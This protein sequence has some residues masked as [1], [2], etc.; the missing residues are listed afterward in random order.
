MP[1]TISGTDC[2]QLYHNPRAAL[3]SEAVLQWSHAACFTCSMQPS[4][5]IAVRCASA[6]DI[7]R[8]HPFVR[9]HIEVGTDFL[10]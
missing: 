10:I 3:V 8:G 2:R 7:A 9:D 6:A 1:S 5:A 4:S